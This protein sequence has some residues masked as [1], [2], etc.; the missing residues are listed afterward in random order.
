MKRIA[1]PVAIAVTVLAVWRYD[2]V[3]DY[4]LTAT[5]SLASAVAIVVAAFHIYW[6]AGGR[7]GVQN[8]IP[9]NPENGERL[10]GPGAIGTVAVALALLLYSALLWMVPR[11]VEPAGFPIRWMLVVGLV[12]LVARV[13]GDGTWTGVLKRV[14]DTG[15]ARADDRWWTPLVALL[16]VGA[17]ASLMQ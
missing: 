6:A 7:V 15:F 9:Q 17:A 8:V 4:A 2:L 13:L 5:Y 12:I 11:D 1:W 10:F 16:A 3:P 14:R